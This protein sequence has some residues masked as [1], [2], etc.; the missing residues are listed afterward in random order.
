MV[1]DLQRLLMKCFRYESSRNSSVSNLNLNGAE[2][3]LRCFTKF[4][5]NQTALVELN[6]TDGTD[7]LCVKCPKQLDLN[8]YFEC[9]YN[10]L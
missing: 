8:K 4:Y 3:T 10:G 1:E 6:Q 7:T 9:C 5:Q 2:L